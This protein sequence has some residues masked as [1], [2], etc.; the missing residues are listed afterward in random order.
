MRLDRALSV[1]VF[2][3]A[4]R[5]VPARSHGALPILMYHGISD[6]SERGSAYYKVNT[7]PAVFERQMRFLKERGYSTIA[8]SEAVRLLNRRES[9]GLRRVVI[10]FDDGYRNFY[11][12]AFPILQKFGFTATMFLPT[13][14]IGEN[15]ASFKGIECMTWDEVRELRKAGIEFG[16]HTVTHPKLVEMNWVDVERE[17]RESRREMETQ[18]GARVTTFAY[19][20]AFP[21]ADPLFVRKFGD[22]LVELGYRCCLTTEVGRARPGDDVYRLKRLPVNSDDD[23]NLFRAKLEGGYDWLAL[24][25]A[26][27]KRVKSFSTQRAR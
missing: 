26:M 9:P 18:L 24:P 5:A 15:R 17:L 2:H 3:P 1:Y 13:G 25:Q 20:F 6:E 21:Q 23:V 16:S 8:L 14:Y 19:P 4:Q 10:S 11:T 12:H 27:V 7:G 22:A